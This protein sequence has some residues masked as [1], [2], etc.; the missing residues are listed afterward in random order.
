MNRSVLVVLALLPAWSAASAQGGRDLRVRVGA[1]AELG[2]QYPGADHDKIEPLFDLSFARG[3]EPFKFKAPDD[4]P[5]LA[6]ISSNGFTV[7]PAINFVGSRRDSDVGAPVG[8]VA[9]TVE[10]GVVAGYRSGG[11]RLRGHL[12]KGS[13]RHKARR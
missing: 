13:G 8:R 3:T 2:P 6:L 10:A 9:P 1:G 7:G 4:S 5:G 11:F 12:L